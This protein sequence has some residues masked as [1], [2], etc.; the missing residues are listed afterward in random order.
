MQTFDRSALFYDAIYAARGKSY[1]AEAARLRALIEDRGIPD[2]STLL[3]VACGTGEHLRFLEPYYRVAGLDASG[4]MLRV[5]RQKLPWVTFYEEDM[6]CFSLN[7]SFEIISCLFAAVGYLPDE[8]TLT[9]AIG[10]MARHLR[11]GGLLLI[12]PALDPDNVA[13]AVTSRMSIDA[14]VEGRPALV[15]RTTSAVRESSVL[16]IR[17][18]YEVTP[19]DGTGRTIRFLEYHPILLASRRVYTRAFQKAGLRTEYLEPRIS[20]I[21]LYLAYKTSTASSR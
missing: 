20:D 11:P 14:V 18:D 17:F 5:A 12:E 13:P 10:Q 6:S 3:D 15:T 7:A 2:G 8:D 9:A 1:R 16:R 21:G 19:S 4:A